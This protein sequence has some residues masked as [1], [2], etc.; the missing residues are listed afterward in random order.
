MADP[1]TKEEKERTPEEWADYEIYLAEMKN[2]LSHYWIPS[3]DPE[4][5]EN[6]Y[7]SAQ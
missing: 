4:D 7:P 2:E 3:T 6:L 5:D 1:N